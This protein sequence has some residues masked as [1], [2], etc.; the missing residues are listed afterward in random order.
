MNFGLNLFTEM[1]GFRLFKIIYRYYLKITKHL[2][3][4]INKKFSAKS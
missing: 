3:N 4:K 2:L 1:N